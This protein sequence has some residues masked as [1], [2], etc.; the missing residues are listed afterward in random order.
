[1]ENKN[2]EEINVTSDSAS[3]LT[4]GLEM[5]E[6]RAKEATEAWEEKKKNFACC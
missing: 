1:M 5:V 3:K 4:A 2:S 6:K